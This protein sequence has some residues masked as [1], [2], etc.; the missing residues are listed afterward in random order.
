MIGKIELWFDKRLL[1]CLK[2]KIVG[3]RRDFTREAIS[4]EVVDD[5]PEGTF[6][7]D[8][9]EGFYEVNFSD[10]F[11]PEP[12]SLEAAKEQYQSDFLRFNDDFDYDAGF[13]RPGS[14]Y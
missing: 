8:N 7:L 9:E 2:K 6:E 4:Y 13:I 5:F 1:G 14:R 3:W 10:L 11:S 12:V